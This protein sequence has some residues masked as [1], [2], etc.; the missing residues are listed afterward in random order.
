MQPLAYGSSHADAQQAYRAMQEQSLT[1]PLTGMRNRRFLLQQIESDIALCLRRYDEA[2]AQRRAL[3]PE[4]ADLC[5]FMVVHLLGELCELS[6]HH[7]RSALRE[8]A[9]GDRMLGSGVEPGPAI[10]PQ[11]LGAGVRRQRGSP[12]IQPFGAGS[13][14]R[15]STR[16]FLARPASVPLSAIGCDE[17]WP[18]VSTR[19]GAMPRV[20][21]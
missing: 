1:D 2:L 20:A 4:S 5:F 7:P 13:R 6:V 11:R 14:R 12:P 19:E 17:P 9:T 16:R 15:I 8:P 18:D 21:R 10:R 3:R